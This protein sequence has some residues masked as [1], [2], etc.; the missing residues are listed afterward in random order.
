MNNWTIAKRIISGGGLLLGF[1][2]LAIGLGVY[3]LKSIEKMA[4]TD[5][6]NDAVPGTIQAVDMTS[7]TFRAHICTLMAG[8]AESAAERQNDIKQVDEYAAIV[9]KAFEDYESTI[10]KEDDRRNFEQLKVLRTTYVNARSAYLALVRD[11]KLEEA[12][13][14]ARSAL[15]PAFFPYRDQTVVVLKYNEDNEVSVTARI[16]QTSLNAVRTMSIVGSLILVLAIAVG[17]IIIRGV[18]RTLQ[19]TV[20]TL[21]DAASQVAAAATQVSSNSQSLAEGASEQAA[22]L[23]ET[24]SSLEEL[25]SMTTQNDDHAQTAKQLSG[26]TREAADKGNT[27][28]QAMDRAMGAIKT[29]SNDIS[30]IIKTIDEI[31]FQTNILALNAAVEAARAGEAG[32]G[33]AVVA[34]EVRALA[35]RSAASAKE[36]ADKIEV[37]IQNGEQGALISGKVAQS[38]GI[39]VE[40]AR[41][42][43]ELVAGI[44]RASQEQK[45]GI[46]QINTAVSQMDKVTQSNAGGA[47]E[48]AAASEE[49]SAQA[50]TMKDAVSSLRNLVGGGGAPAATPSRRAETTKPPAARHVSQPRGASM[51]PIKPVLGNRSAVAAENHDKFFKDN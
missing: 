6:Q 14:F 10:S 33:F 16:V 41:K 11:N 39:I 45:Q 24:S 34:D 36:T 2:V 23:E 32:A 46:G 31:A 3:A 28:M 13:A 42:V 48:T 5:L 25:S 9:S 15:E 43:D 19:L 21:D 44:A 40:K 29:S 50:A 1:L 8:T 4:V 47:E 37:A 49:L 30:K 38:L 26:E 7:Y 20:G 27:D 12:R 18:N 22:S 35:Q 51:T 17:I